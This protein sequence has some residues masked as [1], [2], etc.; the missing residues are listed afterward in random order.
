MHRLIALLVP[1][2]VFTMSVPRATSADATNPAEIGRIWAASVQA[3][4]ERIT[5]PPLVP[6]KPICGR[7]GIPFFSV[8]RM[9][10]LQYQAGDYVQI[11]PS[12]QRRRH[13]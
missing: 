9:G 6:W 3:E 1:V 5:L 13:P 11:R 2:I 12:L 10:W 7:A 4:G 8:L